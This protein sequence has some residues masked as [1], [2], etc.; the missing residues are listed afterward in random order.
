MSI[1][2]IDHVVS[3]PVCESKNIDGSIGEIDGVCTE[4][5]FVIHDSS[6]T[7]VPDCL[8]VDET[9]EGQ[10]HKDWLK[11]YR[12]RNATEQR[13]AEAFNEFEE[14]GDRINLP[15]VLRREAADVYCEAFLTETTDGRDTPT[16]VAA[17]VRL[18]SL[19]T[20]KPI[21]SGRLTESSNIDP[22]QF[23]LS[24]SVL[25][26]NLNRSPPMPEPVDY[27]PFLSMALS[28]DDQQLKAGMRVLEKVTGDLSLVG[29]DPGG[30]AA[31]AL[32]LTGEERT[33]S[34][35][36]EAIGVSTETIRKRVA[37]LR[38]RVDNG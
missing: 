26:D 16:L 35:V 2:Q 28:V 6:D 10:E 23:H 24:Y 27:L 7:T 37:Q 29:K 32:Y 34:D 31:A 9:N 11:T 15:V 8:V 19:Q 20:E 4:C 18:A 1:A 3:C 38:E 25:S 33:Q 21:P 17:C 36:A 22:Q 12:V 30:I 14:I 13:L 5:G